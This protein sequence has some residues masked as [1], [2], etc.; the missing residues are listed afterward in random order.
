MNFFFLNKN[1]YLLRFQPLA[2]KQYV[3]KMLTLTPTTDCSEGKVE[4]V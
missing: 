1:I 2:V 3:F 4:L